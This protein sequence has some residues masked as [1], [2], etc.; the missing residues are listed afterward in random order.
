M[1]NFNAGHRDRLRQ[2]MQKE[3]LSTFQ[4]HEVLELLLF[5]C[6]PRRDTNKLAH[7]LLDSFG[8][9]AGVLDAAPQQLMMVKGVS[10]VT[11]CFLS[12]LKEIWQRYK[13]SQSKQTSLSTVADIIRYSRVLIAESYI[14]KLVVAYVDY[15]SKFLLKE[16]FTSNEVD[17]IHVDPKRIVSS[18]LRVNA[19][20]VLLFHCHPKGECEPS[21]QDDEFTNALFYALG[22]L[23]IVL[24][25]HVIFNAQGEFYSY[26]KNGSMEEISKD[27]SKKFIKNKQ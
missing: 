4:D 5:Q 19:A 13:K 8:G 15:D 9:L 26:S 1:P 12:S 17:K 16:E 23:G 7:E 24:L 2:R 14:E 22:V 18:A 27:F 10:E 11:A 3:G 25:D 20:G 6:I 21:E